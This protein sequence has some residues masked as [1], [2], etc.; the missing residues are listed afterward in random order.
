VLQ[1]A[2]EPEGREKRAPSGLRGIDE[3]R[4]FASILR[5]QGLGQAFMGH[6]I[7]SCRGGEYRP[8]DR[9]TLDPSSAGASSLP[10]ML[11]YHACHLA[12]GD[13]IGACGQQIFQQRAAAVP[14]ASDVDE[15]SH[16]VFD[17]ASGGGRVDRRL[18]HLRRPNTS[19]ARYHRLSPADPPWLCCASWPKSSKLTLE[20]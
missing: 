3:D 20:D 1:S 4:V 7:E 18:C 17:V 8:P 19:P 6:A 14:V 5:H 12:A 2:H 16:G 9:T 10:P 11:A 13:H 15:L